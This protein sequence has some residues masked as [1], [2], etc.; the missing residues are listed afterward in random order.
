MVGQARSTDGKSVYKHVAFKLISFPTLS[1]EKTNRMSLDSEIFGM[2]VVVWFFLLGKSYMT[3]CDPLDC[4]PLGSYVHGIFQARILK[5]VAIPSSRG[6]SQP[7][8]HIPCV[9]RIGRQTL[10][11]CTNCEPTG[12]GRRREN[13]PNQGDEG[14]C[15]CQELR[16]PPM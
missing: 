9:S 15:T 11:H 2:V 3:L 8:D 6:P 7:K 14:R 16:C 1:V 12:R 10:Y 4:S 13:T 5:W